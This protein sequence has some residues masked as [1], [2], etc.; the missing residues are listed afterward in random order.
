MPAL[1]AKVLSA[2]GLGSLLSGGGIMHALGSM[3]Q[4]QIPDVL[5]PAHYNDMIKRG[6]ITGQ[7]YSEGIASWWHGVN[8]AGN[9]FDRIS[10]VDAQQIEV[11]VREQGFHGHQANRI[12]DAVGKLKNDLGIE[13]PKAIDLVTENVRHGTASVKDF[14]DQMEA[15]KDITKN[16]GLSIEQITDNFKEFT[17]TRNEVGGRRGQN[18]YGDYYTAIEK[19]FKGMSALGNSP[20][21]FTKFLFQQG[22]Q[23][24]ALGGG[25]PLL[26]N[27]KQGMKFQMR[28]LQ[29]L[30][31][32]V[33][34]GMPP[35]LG[36]DAYVTMLINAG[37]AEQMFPGLN[38]DQ[39]VALLKAG[40]GGHLAQNFQHQFSTVQSKR[41]A[42]VAKRRED[43]RRKLEHNRELK[44]RDEAH[45]TPD[46]KKAVERF[47]ATHPGDPVP[48]TIT[49]GPNAAQMLRGHK[50]P[51]DQ[52][53]EIER[54]DAYL[55][56]QGVDKGERNRVLAPLRG[57]IGA[58]TFSDAER[59]AQQQMTVVL[60]LDAAETR[61]LFG[62]GQV[63]K[64]QNLHAKN[65]GRRPVRTA[66]GNPH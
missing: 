45:R 56:K 55:I 66:G 40:K 29:S 65:N 5:A 44:R 60:K 52:S 62:T 19:T 26:A 58:T 28:G 42:A 6:Q 9:P 20:G 53:A 13:I 49:P 48:S 34:A 43:Q 57:S 4:S 18:F 14:V 17:Q 10:Q 47:K 8:Q 16:T 37:D 27:S 22:K 41:L 3:L 7:G 59:A 63:T 50:L 31:S 36:I 24:T 11:G 21:A 51:A 35:G 23:L 25:N 54:I 15:L 39:I 12:A 61:R 64:N 33:L 30:I 1:L 2:L 46:E 32:A 38:H